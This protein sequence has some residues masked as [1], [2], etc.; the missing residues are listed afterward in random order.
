MSNDDWNTSPYGQRPEWDN[1]WQRE[2]TLPN[3]QWGRCRLLTPPVIALMASLLLVVVLSTLIYGYVELNWFSPRNPSAIAQAPTATAAPTNQP[4]ATTGFTPTAT[5]APR[6][7]ATPKP[8]PTSTPT[9]SGG[10]KIGANRR[11]L[12]P[13]YCAPASNN[14]TLWRCDVILQNLGSANL[15]WKASSSMRGVTFTPPG[16]VLAPGQQF[17]VFMVIPCVHTG[18][19]YFTGPVNQV[20][21]S[22]GCYATGSAL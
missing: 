18:T 16:G 21:V 19:L 2:E 4:T 13:K 12:A 3:Q 7:T 5:S 8:K 9:P 14:N 11:A 22:W 15:K 20:S 6:P 1:V 10:S 17:D